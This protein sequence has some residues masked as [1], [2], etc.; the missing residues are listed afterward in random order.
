QAPIVFD[1]LLAYCETKTG[2]INKELYRF[3]AQIA[4]HPPLADE[5][6]ST[7]AADFL[8]GRGFAG[9]P[10]LAHRFR[11]FLRDHGHR[12]VEFDPFQPTWIE[13]PALVIDNLKVMLDSH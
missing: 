12:E 6:R 11:R 5:L 7:G 10:E 13:D 8:R 3:A 9:H 2:A 4:E 1:Q